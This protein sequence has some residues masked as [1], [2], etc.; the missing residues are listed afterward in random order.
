MLL[1]ILIPTMHSRAIVFDAITAELRRQIKLCKAT[2]SVEILSLIDSKE[3]TTGAK[4]NDL[5]KMATGDYLVFIDDDDAVSP[6]YIAEVL[7]VINNRPDAD[8]IVYDCHYYLDD[9]FRFNC[10]YSVEYEYS[11]TRK[12]LK[13][14]GSEWRGKPAHTM[15]WKSS[16]AKK[17]SFPDVSKREDFAWV[18]KAYPD[19]KTEVQINKPLYYYM[20]S[21]KK[22]KHG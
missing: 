19:I 1:S 7:N 21:R 3:R 15:V 5:L 16:I 9:I 17:H 20:A 10:K 18:A 8:C 22:K 4:R 14:G 12:L 11:D 6:D 13:N 2:E